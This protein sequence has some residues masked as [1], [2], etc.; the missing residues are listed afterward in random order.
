MAGNR[1]KRVAGMAEIRN[2][3]VP[4]EKGRY[5]VDDMAYCFMRVAAG[6][7]IQEVALSL[8]SSIVE[9]LTRTEGGRIFLQGV[10]PPG[11]RPGWGIKEWNRA[12][13]GVRKANMAQL[14]KKSKMRVDW[15]EYRKWVRRITRWVSLAV[16]SPD[17]C[18]ALIGGVQ[19]LSRR[20]IQR[21]IFHR[22]AV[23]GRGRSL[24]REARRHR[25]KLSAS[26]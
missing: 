4:Y 22:Y 10:P 1:P 6:G 18:Y 2:E 17:G 25:K 13:D 14:E 3:P 5:K 19:G 11:V 9:D 8:S 20:K 26:R 21:N 23:L 12:S 15:T 16:L 24:P 7:T